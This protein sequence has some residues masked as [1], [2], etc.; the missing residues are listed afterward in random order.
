MA[1]TQT[2]SADEIQ[3][4]EVVEVAPVVPELSVQQQAQIARYNAKE[5]EAAM[6]ES[7]RIF[8]GLLPAATVN[9]DSRIHTVDEIEHGYELA[10]DAFNKRADARKTLVAM[11]AEQESAELDLLNTEH[12][13][14]LEAKRI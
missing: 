9:L 7:E 11:W 8:D 5:A 12:D 6:L 13:A 4:T 1:K 3:P 14:L 2:V 10:V